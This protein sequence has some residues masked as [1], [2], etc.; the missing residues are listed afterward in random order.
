MWNVMSLSGVHI[1][2]TNRRTFMAGALSGPAGMAAVSESAEAWSSVI[3]LS[4]ASVNNRS[5]SKDV[6]DFTRGVRKTAPPM[7]VA[8]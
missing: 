5:S 7:A 1:V 8:L 4:E 3:P 6:P 2:T